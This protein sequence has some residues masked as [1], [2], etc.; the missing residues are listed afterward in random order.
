M[1]LEWDPKRVGP[2]VLALGMFDGVHLGHQALLR[3]GRELADREGLPLAVCTFEPHPL[4]VLCPEKKPPRLTTPEERA[5]IMEDQSVDILC[6]NTF[7]RELAAQPPEDFIR[8]MASVYEPKHVVVGYNFT[9]GD[10]GRGNGALLSASQ[11]HYGYTTHIV[12]EVT[13][14][15]EMVSSTHIRE[16]LQQ[17]K[18][19]RAAELLGG[20]YRMSGVVENGKHIGRTLGF[21]TANIH[22]DAQKVLPAFGVHACLLH[23]SGK[24]Y[25]AVVNVGRHPTLPEG[26]ITV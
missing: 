10:R 15:G 18:M 22:V 17:G 13:V 19:A 21:P 8:K 4:A 9:F 11:E 12:P 20:P 1:R 5:E 2:C 7:N 24:L 23:T 16:L 3:L 14:E 26:H 25:P 6:L